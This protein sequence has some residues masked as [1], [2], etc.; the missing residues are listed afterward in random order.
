LLLRNILFVDCVAEHTRLHFSQSSM[1]VDE[2]ISNV[3]TKLSEDVRFLNCNRNVI[4]NMDQILKTEECSFL[5]KNGETVP[6][7]QRDC[8]TVKREFLQ[9]SLRALRKETSI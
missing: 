8:S 5:L 4:V 6:I 7:R 3:L 2:R 9:Y 1:T